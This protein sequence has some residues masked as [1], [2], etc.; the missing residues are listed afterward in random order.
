MDNQLT[1]YGVLGMKWGVHKAQKSGSTYTYKS[2]AQ[3]KAEKRLNNAKAKGAKSKTIDKYSRE[4]ET[5]KIRDSRRDNYAKQTSTGKAVVRAVLLGPIG[6]MG[7]NSMRAAGYSAARSAI[8][9]NWVTTLGT[10][11]LSAF[12]NTVNENRS[13]RAEMEKRRLIREELGK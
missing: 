10:V 6:A 1:H 11:G 5:L 3:S 9:N 8:A 4:L 7:Y 13:A 2:K 12:S